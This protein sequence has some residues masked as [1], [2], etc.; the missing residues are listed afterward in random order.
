MPRGARREGTE[1][2]ALRAL[3]LMTADLV[4]ALAGGRA[5]F[6]VGAFQD[7]VAAEAVAE[8]RDGLAQAAMALAGVVVTKKIRLPERGAKDVV[9]GDI[10]PPDGDPGDD[11]PAEKFER[12][13]DQFELGF[14]RGIDLHAAVGGLSSL[15]RGVP[16]PK[17]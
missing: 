11:D 6:K 7:R 9:E 2:R 5:L 1:E 10:D 14:A 4:I 8:L 3:C 12:R 16:D 13:G 15:L 17:R